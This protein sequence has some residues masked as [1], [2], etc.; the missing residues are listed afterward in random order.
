MRYVTWTDIG[1][2]EAYAQAVAAISGY[3]WTKPGEVTWVLPETGR[4]SSTARGG[5]RSPAAARATRRSR[6][7]AGARRDPAAHARV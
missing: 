7:D 6:R 3:D 2:E 4:V 1:D 5:T